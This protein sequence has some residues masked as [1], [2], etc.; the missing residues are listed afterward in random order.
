MKC[1][2]FQEVKDYMW[3][4][5]PFLFYNLSRQQMVDLNLGYVYLMDGSKYPGVKILG[6]NG[7]DDYK[8]AVL[9][10]STTDA[11]YSPVPS[12][13]D[14]LYKKCEG[15]NV[16]IYNGGADGYSSTMELIKL[17]RDILL[18]K[19]DMVIVYDGVNDPAS[20]DGYSYDIEY[21]RKI[22]S[23][24]LTKQSKK[25]VPCNDIEM[26]GQSWNREAVQNVCQ[27]N[28]GCLDE[29]ESFDTWLSN[30]EIMHAIAQ[31]RGI[32]FFSFL[33]PMLLSKKEE[34]LTLKEKSWI[35]AASIYMREEVFKAKRECRRL[36]EE[37]HIADTHEYMYDLSYIFDDVDVYFDECHVYEEGNHIIAD[38]IWEIIENH[39]KS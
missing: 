32:K 14:F 1:L 24:A 19:P 8:I 31:N 18:L 13:V 39:V 30:I 12:W 28:V 17:L 38:K 27:I 25:G 6:R 37:R 23:F 11:E 2:G 34:F 36:M 9:G 29:R 21:L 26:W 3:I 33:Q 20:N 22:L 5:A 10:G 16:T 7:D 15:H 35:H 4:E